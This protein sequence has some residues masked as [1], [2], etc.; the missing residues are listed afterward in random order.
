MDHAITQYCTSFCSSGEVCKQIPDQDVV[1][2][3]LK[4]ATND[5]LSQDVKQ[6]AAICLAKLATGDP[7]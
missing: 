4:H 7:K 1:K 6:N 3:L 5:T 2:T